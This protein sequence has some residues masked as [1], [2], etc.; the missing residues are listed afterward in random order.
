MGLFLTVL[1]DEA[2]GS[3]VRL[4]H[5]EKMKNTKH[6]CTSYIGLRI[7]S[8]KSN[9]LPMRTN[10]STPIRVHQHLIDSLNNSLMLGNRAIIPQL[11]Q[12]KDHIPLT[13]QVFV[14]LW[15]L[16]YTLENF[17]KCREFYVLL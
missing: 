9:V 15:L 7:N 11:G 14:Q 17:G 10:P 12:S 13:I 5:V 1:E 4:H 3:L 8:L 2:H 6:S 16:Y